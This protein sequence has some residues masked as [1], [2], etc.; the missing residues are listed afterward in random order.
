NGYVASEYNTE[1]IN[2]IFESQS[3]NK[4]TYIKFADKPTYSLA[5]SKIKEVGEIYRKN[6]GITSFTY[7]HNDS[8]Y[9]LVFSNE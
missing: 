3:D 9:T 4:Y 7:Y 8:T 2:K 6:K 5:K 1:T